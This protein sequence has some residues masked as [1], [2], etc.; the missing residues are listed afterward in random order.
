VV[1]FKL[2]D[3][4]ALVLAQLVCVDKVRNPDS[5]DHTYDVSLTLEAFNGVTVELH[6][7]D[8]LSDTCDFLAAALAKDGQ[9]PGN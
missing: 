7:V 5:A 9:D 6:A 8:A 4:I 3:E 1:L 2:V